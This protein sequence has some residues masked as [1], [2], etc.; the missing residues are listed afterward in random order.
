MTFL[1]DRPSLAAKAGHE[2]IA[3]LRA[4]DVHP[5]P[6]EGT[7]PLDATVV[8]SEA[9][10]SSVHLTFS[11]EGTPVDESRLGSGLASE[12]EAELSRLG[13][14]QA[15]QGVAVFPPRLHFVTGDPTT[16]HVDSSRLHYFDVD[17]GL[18]LR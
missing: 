7:Y 2:V 18:A 6:R 14:G 13:Q 17:S 10:G 4:E 9:L 8:L 3:G 12:E 1:R 11:L 16:I 15:I 5:D